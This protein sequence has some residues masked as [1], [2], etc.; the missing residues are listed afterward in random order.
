MAAGGPPGSSATPQ[1]ELRRAAAG[2]GGEGGVRGGGKMAAERRRRRRRRVGVRPPPTPP[3]R[4][5]SPAPPRPA[6]RDR[7]EQSRSPAAEPRRLGRG[8]RVPG[9]PAAGTGAPA[10][11]AASSSSFSSS[12]RSS[13]A[14]VSPRAAPPPA[15]GRGSRCRPFERGGP[16]PAE[17]GGGGT[18]RSGCQPGG[19]RWVSAR[20]NGEEG[21]REVGVCRAPGAAP[22]PRGGAAVTA[23][24]GTGRPGAAMAAGGA[25]CPSVCAPRPLLG[26]REGRVCV[27][28]GGIRG[29]ALRGLNT[30]RPFS[31]SPF[32][33]FKIILKR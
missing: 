19:G 20:G 26:G 1:H 8:P 10:A 25:L 18:E 3:P 23:G 5:P 30:P 12:H 2:G 6:G 17:P 29:P 13:L 16:E 7:G 24:A 33:L 22:G 28:G 32:F 27:W 11:P 31:F 15:S 9:S 21:R 4:P 14:A